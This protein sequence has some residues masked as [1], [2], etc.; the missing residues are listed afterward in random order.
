MPQGLR[1]HNRMFVVGFIILAALLAAGG[2][3]A[4]GMLLW[5]MTRAFFAWLSRL[6]SGSE[7]APPAEALP[8]AIP[9]MPAAEPGEPG[10]LSMILNIGFLYS[11]SRSHS[12]GTVF[13]PAL[14]IQ[15][16]RRHPAQNDGQAI[17]SAA[18]RDTSGCRVSG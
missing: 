14:V 12:C 7:E 13:Y 6:S 16:Y 3:R 18:Q 8:E 10:L 5:N 11:R 2:G 9:P 4:V 15:K 17:V 1:R